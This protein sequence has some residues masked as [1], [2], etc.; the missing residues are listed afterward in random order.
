MGYTRGDKRHCYGHFMNIICREHYIFP[1][2]KQMIST[3]KDAYIRK[4][5]AVLGQTVHPSS[6]FSS[7]K[8]VY[9]FKKENK[10]AREKMGL[11]FSSLPNPSATLASTFR[12]T[13]CAFS[14]LALALLPVTF[15]RHPPPP[16]PSF[17]L[18]FLIPPPFL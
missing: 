5:F 6:S 14:I 15:D 10:E 4:S 11:F 16:P 1:Q 13:S 3:L 12:I 18:N 9:C 17:Q 2:I 8:V 7:R